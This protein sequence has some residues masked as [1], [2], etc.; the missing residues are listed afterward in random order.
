[1][2]TC[3]MKFGGAAMA[4]IHRFSSL[5]RLIETRKKVFERIV[6]V[7]S[8]MG[9]TTN[10]LMELAYSIHPK[11]PSRELDMLVT[12]GERVSMS[13]LAM[14]LDMRGIK[15]QSF[16]GSQA[17]IV[18]T[19]AH[20]DAEILELRPQR[21]IKALD[22]KKI[23]IVAGFQ[24]VS[25]KKEIT[26]LGRGGS[27][28]S[29]VALAVCLGAESVEFYKDVPGI[30]KANPKKNS[31]TQIFPSLSYGEA[32][33]IV[34]EGAE[35]L[36]SKALKWAESHGVVLEIRPFYEPE[37]VGTRV[38]AIGKRDIKENKRVIAQSCL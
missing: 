3:I 9:Q 27:D 36:H 35:V 2:S 33:E 26:T 24:G 28:T 22:Q 29:A 31:K 30:G 20:T 19:E 18:T 17:G 12:A 37:K 13:L 10:K 15:A 16:T 7:V 8:A 32:L 34:G 5:A 21:V 6:V 4:D 23:V 25:F 1:M 11:P 38:S 14:A